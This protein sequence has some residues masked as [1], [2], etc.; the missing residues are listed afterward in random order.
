[1]LNADIT[2]DTAISM[3]KAL[4]GTIKK[5]LIWILTGI[6]LI[7]AS[8]AGDGQFAGRFTIDDIT[9]LWKPA[10]TQEPGKAV[11]SQHSQP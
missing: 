3:G 1:L 9:K 7:L 6:C 5:T 2:T 11:S 8:C 10:K 4:M